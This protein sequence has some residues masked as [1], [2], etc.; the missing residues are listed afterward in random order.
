[1]VAVR[2]PALNFDEPVPAVGVSQ[3]PHGFD[4]IAG[5]KFLSRFHYG[6]FGTPDQ[7][8]LDVLPAP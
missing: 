6:N 1:L 2:I 3:V 8:G 5:F 7:F 4:G